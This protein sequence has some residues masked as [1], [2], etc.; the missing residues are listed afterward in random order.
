MIKLTDKH[1]DFI[2]NDLDKRGIIL[3]DLKENIV[4]H[5]CCII[6]EEMPL[7]SDFKTYYDE[8]IKRFFNTELNELQKETDALLNNTYL[9]FLKK[10]IQVTGVVSV[11]LL[12][13]GIYSKFNHLVGS[14]VFFIFGTILFTFGFI[15]SLILLKFKDTSSKNNTFLVVLGFFII[16]VGSAGCLFKIMQ[17][18]MTTQLKLISILT[19]LFIFIPV[20]YFSAIKNEGNKFITFIN[21]VSMLVIGILFFLMNVL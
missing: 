3:E 8:I 7:D 16:A 10:T 11:V 13:I 2:I 18:P 15:P 19:F 14:G 4:D 9:P 20:Y 6:E 1:I 12:L 21:T 5:V 17:W